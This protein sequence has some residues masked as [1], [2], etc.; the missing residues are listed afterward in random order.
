MTAVLSALVAAAIL[1]AAYLVSRLLLPSHRPYRYVGHRQMPGWKEA[2]PFY[3]FRCKVHGLVE[4]HPAGYGQVLRCPLCL[5][6]DK[7]VKY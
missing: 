3:E 1:V 4:S 6:L 7:T 5:A 2:L